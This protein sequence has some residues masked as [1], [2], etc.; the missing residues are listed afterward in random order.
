[1]ATGAGSVVP[2][3]RGWWYGRCLPGL[4]AQRG[5]RIS[6]LTRTPVRRG[7]P[8]GRRRHHP[9]GVFSDE[10][11]LA[12]WLS[13]FLAGQKPWLRA[14]TALTVTGKVDWVVLRMVPLQVVELTGAVS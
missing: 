14:Q 7:S 6:E 11:T 1:M 4:P 9:I 2:A 13:V 3:P 10:T 12:A 8:P 5:V